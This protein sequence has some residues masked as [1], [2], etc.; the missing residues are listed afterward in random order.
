MSAE[1]GSVEPIIDYNVVPIEGVFSSPEKEIEVP[2][3]EFRIVNGII[4]RE[5]AP[6]ETHVEGRDEKAIVDT[7][8][9]FSQVHE[10]RGDEDE[11]V[12]LVGDPIPGVHYVGTYEQVD[13][14]PKAR[15]AKVEYPVGYFSYNKLKDGLPEELDRVIIILG[16]AY[17]EHEEHTGQEASEYLVGPQIAT[18][19]RQ[20][21]EV[22]YVPDGTQPAKSFSLRCIVGNPHGE[23]ILANPQ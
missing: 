6:G 19:N 10:Q 17:G 9:A 16:Q 23:A 4:K 13:T 18:R 12:A 22:S 14:D 20:T 11:S 15:G 1:F 2:P 8:F 5:P 7:D 3:T 21:G